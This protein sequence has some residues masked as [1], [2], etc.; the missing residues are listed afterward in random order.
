MLISRRVCF[1]RCSAAK[2]TAPSTGKS[3]PILRKHPGLYKTGER[4]SQREVPRERA[5]P[6]RKPEVLA[7]A[8]GWEQLRAAAEN[9]ADAVYFGVSDFN[10]RARA[11]NFDVESLPEVMGFLHERGMKGYLVLNVLVFD[12]ELERLAT[13]AQAARRA[14]V[15]AAIVQ[16]IGAVELIKA[17][18]PGLA[19]HGSTQMTVTSVEGMEFAGNRGIERVVVGRELSISDIAEIASN[20]DLEIEAFVHGALC[21]SY[22]GQCFSS[23]AWGGRSANRGQCA[24][25]CR[26][27]YGIVVDGELKDFMESYVLSPQD[28]AAVDLMPELIQAGIVS[29]KIEGRLK[30]PEY[31]AMTTSVYRHAVDAAWDALQAGQEITQSELIDEETFDELR[32]V[33]SRA[34][35]ANFD[36][37]THGFLDGSR[38]QTLVRGRQPRHRGV[39]IGKVIRVDGRNN[40]LEIQLARTVKLGDGLVIDQGRPEEEEVGGSVFSISPLAQPGKS[41]ARQEKLQSAPKGT[42]VSIALG[43]G[44]GKSS[45]VSGVRVGDLVFKNKDDVLMSRLRSSF[46]SV[47]STERRRAPVHVNINIE[48]GKPLE[49]QLFRPEDALNQV[50]TAQT[51]SSVQV[52]EN[53]PTR[54]NDIRK[55]VGVHLGD[56]GSFFL[57]SFAIQCMEEE[58]IFIPMKEV[59]DARRRAVQAMLTAGRGD[60]VKE[61]PNAGDVVDTL[62]DDIRGRPPDPNEHL[63]PPSMPRLRVLCRTPEQVAGAA[64]VDWLEEI[65]LDFLEVKGLAKAVSLV[66]R[67]G[68]RAVVATPRILKPQ[69]KHLW[70]F[71]VKLGCPLLVRSAGMIQRFAELGGAGAD[72]FD[73]DGQRIGVVPILEGDFSL[74]ATNA[75][76]AQLLLDQ[77]LNSL[78]LTFDCSARQITGVL[79]RLGAQSSKIEVIIHSNLPIFH[80]EHCLFARFLSDGDDYT[81]CGRPCESKTIHIRDASGKDHRVEADMGTSPHPTHPFS[82][83]RNCA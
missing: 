35:D 42:P 24:Q 48:L 25:A 83:D 10:A 27:P 52:A 8:G 13:V 65:V 6:L 64:S 47:S 23:E 55:A 7:P 46:E 36:G 50:F 1:T 71:Y 73:D 54:A 28:L 2:G 70:E 29:L 19:I 9:G 74:N 62:L 75:V 59:K 38:H 78:A 82:T 12:E 41:G 66:E 18:A 32:C 67:A 17:A 4:R 22:S 79:D 5:R 68:K 60:L 30:G 63:N 72:V 45:D 37:L 26:L 77:G 58:P 33:F 49:I 39:F 14:G 40:R 21:V 61:L 3:K 16:D 44:S 69:E 31:V 51:E 53:K 43:Y 56:D 20:T 34:Q 80:T 57:D 81:T 15:D 11:E 76:T